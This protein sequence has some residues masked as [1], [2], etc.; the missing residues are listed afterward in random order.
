MIQQQ[1]FPPLP[2]LQND[3]TLIHKHHHNE[4]ANPP[5]LTIRGLVQFHLKTINVFVLVL[6]P[7]INKDNTTL[8]KKL[9]FYQDTNRS[10]I[11]A[12]LPTILVTPV[13]LCL[14]SPALSIWECVT[15]SLMPQGLVLATAFLIFSE[16]HF[17]LFVWHMLRFLYKY[18]N[19]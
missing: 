6:K 5:I 3:I 12:Y 4:K 19:T 15:H 10:L 7:F 18:L 14:P 17:G 1:H 16:N 2:H 13:T 11:D 8:S 9:L